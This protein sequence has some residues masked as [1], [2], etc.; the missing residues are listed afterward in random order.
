MASTYRGTLPQLTSK[1]PFLTEGGIETTLVY[2]Y[3][4]DLPQFA[5]FPLLAAANGK[6][7]L[8]DCYIP[9]VDLALESKTG[10]VLETPTWRAS[11]VWVEK[12]GYPASKVAEFNREAVELLKNIRKEYETQTTPIVISG[13]LGPLGDAYRRPGEIS[14]DSAY[15]SYYDQVKALSESGV[16]MLSIMTVTDVKEAIAAVQLAREFGIP[17]MVSFTVET[18][19]RLLDDRLLADIIREVDEA[20]GNYTAY[21]GV[22]CARNGPVHSRKIGCYTG[23]CQHKEPSGT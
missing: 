16:D 18:N 20:T 7:T 9:F 12:L 13:N 4:Y 14:L 15:A 19:G 5:A 10:I 6:Q 2:K 1:T 21:F 17:I 23:E 11:R 8:H 3:G 22:N